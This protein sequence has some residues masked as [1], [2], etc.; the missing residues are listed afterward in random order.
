MLEVA[1]ERDVGVIL[2]ES[3]FPT[4]TTRQIA[5]RSGASVAVLPGG[6]NVAKGESWFDRMDAVVAALA[7]AAG[8]KP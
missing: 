2:Q 7:G 6:P 8:T 4:T 3:W 1:R 5:D